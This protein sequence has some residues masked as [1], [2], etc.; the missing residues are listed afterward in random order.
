MLTSQEVS[1]KEAAWRSPR[2]PF[3][4]IHLDFLIELIFRSLPRS[5][6]SIDYLEFRSLF[7]VNYF[8]HLCFLDLATSSLK[9]CVVSSP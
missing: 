5:S 9:M 2:V 8:L 3:L 1:L 4:E 7:S 6:V